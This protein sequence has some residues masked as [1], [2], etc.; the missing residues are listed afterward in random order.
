MVKLE[1]LRSGSK[2]LVRD[3]FGFSRATVKG[4][5]Q[6]IFGSPGIDYTLD[7]SGERHWAHLDSVQQVLR[8]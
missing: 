7:A 8:Y 5:E 4:I 2:I 3:G 1:Q 6:D